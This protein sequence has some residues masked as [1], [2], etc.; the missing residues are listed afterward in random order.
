MATIKSIVNTI[1]QSNVHGLALAVE[2]QGGGVGT[3]IDWRWALSTLRC[4]TKVFNQYGGIIKVLQGDSKAKL[5]LAQFQS[6]RVC[7]VGSNFARH[8]V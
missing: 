2:E 7:C 1:N 5:L 8:S 3:I 6:K 4:I